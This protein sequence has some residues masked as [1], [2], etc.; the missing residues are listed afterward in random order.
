MNFYYFTCSN[1]AQ[2]RMI[3]KGLNSIA[4][5][6]SSIYYLED[7]L[8]LIIAANSKI[9]ND[10]VL[11]LNLKTCA[12]TSSPRNAFEL[13]LNWACYEI[14]DN[15]MFVQYE[16]MANYEGNHMMLSFADVSIQRS[17]DS[18]SE[19]VRHIELSVSIDL[20]DT[21]LSIQNNLDFGV[22][23]IL[24]DITD[25]SASIVLELTREVSLLKNR[26]KFRLGISSQ[27]EVI[28]RQYLSHV[29]IVAD[30]GAVFSLEL[31]E[32][33]TSTHT[34]MTLVDNSIAQGSNPTQSIFRS[35]EQ[36]I[37]QL[38]SMGV[39]LANLIIVLGTGNN[40]SKAQISHML[41]NIQQFTNLPCEVM[42][43]N[44][45]NSYIDAQDITPTDIALLSNYLMSRDIDY[46]GVSYIK[47]G[48]QIN[49]SLSKFC[50]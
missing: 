7:Q 2:A 34:Y 3:V 6:Y 5:K 17:S 32:Q 48:N 41:R 21:V 50:L 18:L 36:R 9:N 30:K 13:L 29:D 44:L 26:Y 40:K 19:L 16:D 22:T 47:D 33:I 12:I 23:I 43:D 31:I 25:A 15:A 42:L 24:F 4:S 38:L 39:D 1:K 10:M 20:F 27:D 49:K 14:L 46:I 45:T 8:Y 35:S 28:I 37:E 11:W